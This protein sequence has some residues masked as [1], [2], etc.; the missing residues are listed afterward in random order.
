MKGVLY[1]GYVYG[2]DLDSSRALRRSDVKQWS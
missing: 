2:P 1:F